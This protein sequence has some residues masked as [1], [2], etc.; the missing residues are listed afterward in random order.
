M[1][2]ISTIVCALISISFPFVVRADVI[3]PQIEPTFENQSKLAVSVLVHGVEVRN[4]SGTLVATTSP[5]N[6]SYTYAPGPNYFGA[7]G[8]SISDSERDRMFKYQVATYMAYLDLWKGVPFTNGAELV[9]TWDITGTS[10]GNVSA[11]L[12]TAGE[13]F[14]VV[15]VPNALFQDPVTEVCGGVSEGCD[16]NALLEAGTMER[17]RDYF[18]TVAKLHTLPWN[19]VT[20]FVL[21]MGGTLFTVSPPSLGASNI[22]F[23]PGVTG[24][25]LYQNIGGKENKVWEASLSFTQSD[26][27]A[28]YMDGNGASVNDLYTK[29]GEAVSHIDIPFVGVDVYKTFFEKLQSYKDNGSITDYRIFPYDWRVSPD[30]TAESPVQYLDGPH[31]LEDELASLASSSRTGKVTIIG[32][33]NGGLVAKALLNKLEQEGKQGLVDTLVLLDV[34][35]LGTPDTLSATLHGDFGDLTGKGGIYLSKKNARS[36][37]E[38]MPDAYALL[39]S[40]HYFDVVSDPVVDVS[41]APHLR[42]LA[43]VASSSISTASELERYVTGGNG[44]AKPAVDDVEQPNTLSQPLLTAAKDLHRALDSWTPPIGVRVLQIAGWGIDTPKGITY[45]EEVKAK[46][47]ITFVCG[48]KTVLTHKVNMTTD[49][50]GTVVLPSEVAMA[51]TST[52]YLDLASDADASGNPRNHANVTESKLFQDLL[53]QLVIDRNSTVLPAHVSTS[54]PTRG[55][56]ATRLRLRVLSPVT[57]DAYDSQGR[58]TGL[59]RTQNGE[60]SYVEEQIPNSYYREYGEGKYL[61]LSANDVVQIKMNGTDTGT[62]TYEVTEVGTTTEMIVAYKDIPV[63]ASTTATMDIAR[64]EITNAPLSLDYNGDGVVDVVL[65]SSTAQEDWNTYVSL[66]LLHVQSMN[67]STSSK[68]QLTAKFEN[69]RHL[70]QKDGQWNGTDDDRDRLDVKKNEHALAQA[71][72]KLGKIQTWVT[73]QVVTTNQGKITVLSKRISRTQAEAVL[74]MI[75][76]LRTRIQQP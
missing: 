33:S 48:A 52:Y 73:T 55:N 28:L 57:L 42:A 4:G 23:L 40:P 63:T 22:L 75:I 41:N 20:G 51:S 21:Y 53:T 67:L 36:L 46:C 54:T 64:S 9:Q 12:P 27:K 16:P 31:L 1:K 3:A 25:R 56:T 72:R 24:S 58:H 74:G 10:S 60:V 30:V 13:Y 15:H 29:S 19:E 76:H 26:I 34:P 7:N 71:V 5:Q 37:T 66:I 6:I 2:T 14:F 44:R 17:E 35:Q 38:N 50:D 18:R 69:I 70:L 49:G 61:G 62:F 65:A 47:V 39:P 43:G 8:G 45:T 11:V 32:H 68:F 59:V